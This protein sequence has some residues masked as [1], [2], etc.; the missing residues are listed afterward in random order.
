MSWCILGRAPR[1]PSQCESAT[2]GDS[3]PKCDY[4]KKLGH[5]LPVGS[6]TPFLSCTTTAATMIIEITRGVIL[7]S[8]LVYCIEDNA[9][10]EFG[11]GIGLRFGFKV[12][13]L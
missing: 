3:R 7:C 5:D 2:R 13:M 1:V 4:I 8:L 11:G 6:L 10:F 12:C 9:I